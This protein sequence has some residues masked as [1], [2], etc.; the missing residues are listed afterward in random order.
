MALD[1]TQIE[2]AVFSEIVHLHPARLTLSE[3]VLRMADGQ[4]GSECVS[5]HDSVQALKRSGLVRQSGETIEPTYAALRAHA[6]LSE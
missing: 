2:G 5:I 3:L 6:L 1:L 4:D